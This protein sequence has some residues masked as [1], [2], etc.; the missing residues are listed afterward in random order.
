MIKGVCNCF[1]CFDGYSETFQQNEP[2]QFKLLPTTFECSA[3][4]TLNKIKPNFTV[5]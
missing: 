4:P 5:E 2:H 1:C 3:V